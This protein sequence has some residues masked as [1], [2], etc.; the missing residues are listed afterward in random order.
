MKLSD[1]AAFKQ[2]QE[3]VA[4]ANRLEEQE[5]KAQQLEA[6]RLRQEKAQLLNREFTARVEEYEQMAGLV[7]QKLGEIWRVAQEYSRLTSATPPA[8][9]EDA[10]M[11]VNVP[12]LIPKTSP[13]DMSSPYSTTRIAV[14]NY[15]STMG[16]A[17]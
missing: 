7:H 3:E 11:S 12:S 6:Q 1:H 14:M 16:K 4:E 17:W 10:F 15:F 9:V 5:R 2:M 8:F 13:Y